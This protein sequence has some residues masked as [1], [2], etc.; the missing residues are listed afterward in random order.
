MSRQELIN[1]S[2]H[3]KVRKETQKENKSFFGVEKKETKK[4][5][6]LNR[7]IISGEASEQTCECWRDY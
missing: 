5:F 1:P 4:M 7:K 6:W 2:V 3:R